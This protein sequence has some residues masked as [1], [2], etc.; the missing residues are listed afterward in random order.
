MLVTVQ[1]HTDTTTIALSDENG[2][3]GWIVDGAGARL[4]FAELTDDGWSVVAQDGCSMRDE[5]GGKC[6]R[7][8]VP[9]DG[10]SIFVIDGPNGRRTVA[11]R[12]STFDDR[13]S[14]II[15][16][17]NDVDVTIGRG[18]DNVVSYPSRF[19]SEHHAS[20]KWESGSFSIID[21]GSANGVYVN[22]LRIEPNI[23]NALSFG[24]VITILGLHIALGDRFIS[25]NDPQGLVKIQRRSD[26]VDFVAPK[27][28]PDKHASKHERKHFYPALRFARSIERKS[29]SIDA[30]PQR[31]R[32]DD[33]PVI[34]RIGPSLVMAT[35]SVMSAA[36]SVSYMMDSSGGAIRAVPMV[37]MAVSML[38]GS[39]LWPILN[40]RF[41]DKKRVQGETL[42]LT[43]YSQYLGKVRMDLRKEAELQ[44]EILRENRLKPSRC[45]DEAIAQGRLFMSRTSLHHDY[46]ELR[47]GVG[48]EPMQVDVRFPDSHFDM[49]DDDLRDA[50]EKLSRE[51]RVLRD[52]P[53][54][55]SLID[56]SVLGL[57]GARRSTDAY[58]RS[59]I[60]Q[61]AAL[62][63][64]ADVKLVML[65]DEMSHDRWRFV[66]YLPHC[67][68]DDRAMRFFS[69]SLEAAN[70]L[71]MFFEREL[72][73]RRGAGDF[74]AR[75]AKP[76]YVVLCPSKAIYD[77][78]GIVNSILSLKSNLGFSFI[79]CAEKMHDLP[80]QC[81]TVI[82]VEDDGESGYMLDRDDPSGNRRQI[83]FDEPVSLDCAE[84]FA[85]YVARARLDL[86]VGG[87]ELPDRLGFLEMLGASTVERLNVLSRWSQN[88]ASNSLATCV[89]VDSLGE[90]FMLN[91][92][93]DFHGPHGLIA[94]TT[95]SGKSEFIIAYILS[96]AISYS[97]EDVAFVLID[98]KGGGLAKAFDNDRFRLP[99]VAGTITNLDGAAITRSLVSVKSELKRRQALFNEAREVVG[100]DN[101][102][103]YKYLDLY[104]QGRVKEQC[105][106]LIIVADEFAELKQQEPE[107]M[108]ELISAARIGRSLGVHL[109][110]ATQ[111]PSG[112]VNDQIWSNSRFK[113]SLKV[114]DATD[115]QEIIRRPD[116]AEITQPGRFFLMVGYNEYFA[117]GQS[118]YSGVPYVPGLG[119]DQ[120]RGESVD[121]VSDSGRVL[122][123]VKPPQ[124]GPR[125]DGR[126]E[127]V[128]VLEHLVAAAAE[129]GRAAKQ[130]W[131]DPIPAHIL[132]SEVE[133]KYS[134]AP[135]DSFC[136]NPVIGAFD[137][138][139]AQEQGILTLPLTAGGNAVLYGTPDG[140]VEAMMQTLLYSLITTHSPQTLN[141]YVLDFGGQS[142]TAF[143]AA[144][145]VGDVVLIDDEEK[146]RRFFDFMFGIIAER[147]KLFTPFGGSHERYCESYGNCPSIAILVN[148][149]SAFMEVYEKYEDA[150]IRLARESVSA[151]IRMVV[152]AESLGAMRLRLRNSFRQ[153]LACD[154]ADLSDYAMLF[155]SVRG[156]PKA[157]G[158][159]RGLVQMEDGVM[160]FQAA[161]VCG[162]DESDYGFVS[163]RCAELARGADV[164]APAI[165]TAPE[166]VTLEM[167]DGFW[168]AAAERQIPYGVFDDSLS[169]AALDFSDVPIAR[170]AFH[171]R[172]EGS[173][174]MSAFI[175]GACASAGRWEVAVLDLAGV[176]EEQPQ[177]CVLATRKP[178]LAVSYLEN[179]IAAAD[180]KPSGSASKSS[181]VLVISGIVS[182][183]SAA[184]YDFASKL[185][186]YL[187]SLRSGGAISVLLFDCAADGDYKYEDW[188]K[189]HLTA[190]DGLW[191]GP[192][193]DSQS[194]ISTAYNARFLPD[195]QM[196]EKRG[197][198]VEGGVVRLVHLV[199]DAEEKEE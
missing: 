94:G 43:S 74:N 109:I 36:V 35:A 45:I 1:S 135:C 149:I 166:R 13:Q 72:S 182:F 67:F 47:V 24:D 168:R 197:Y 158:F 51:P 64:Y 104:R 145:H 75:D 19:V 93:E 199:S 11:S 3:A 65:C 185:R 139:A 6:E 30:P 174:F 180:A 73:A 66:S 101:V 195:S 133:R 190:K 34:M 193:V 53:L 148:G 153:T 142:L 111:K 58:L 154:M 175:K 124:E 169:V 90:P 116:A 188:F 49:V 40:K 102:D 173:R 20:L 187:K 46:L 22:G 115:S 85:R 10:T 143:A 107:F 48:E 61:I 159:G 68:S 177:G 165:P 81:R 171:K 82:A 16:F 99:H 131:L 118:G 54:A 84:S 189:A 103:I 4:A 163:A 62:H 151:G 160:E 38:A 97:P 44:E 110:L 146:V 37:A 88:N 128:A 129:Q 95:G 198:A 156:L 8:T 176:L 130:L 71:D 140:G 87:N 17:A 63:S 27:A 86:D 178:E 191:V 157:S 55:H 70:S 69:A 132:L 39:V 125:G 123:S 25:L 21:L 50:V 26:F 9:P 186:D 144:P 14:R 79:A 137:N 105:P 138:P 2:G 170:V 119:K 5:R 29:F 181:K 121:Y 33:T 112:V 114:A 91:L 113:I 194:A 164:S 42:R 56:N 52:V 179:L 41:Q 192:G 31:E 136:L 161:S 184:D 117:Q 100:G 167:V 18:A 183:L 7:L 127:I 98:Y 126:S 89:G 134:Y 141:A 162:Q 196:D 76:Y 120:A 155:G 122:L 12:P 106:H 147:R 78:A 108:D 96:M 172:R 59:L 80:K 150:L 28:D 83:V 152:S 92:H 60:V 77:K 32:E 57:V 23:A 15:G